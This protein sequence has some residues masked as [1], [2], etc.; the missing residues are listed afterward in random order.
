MLGR[1]KGIEKLK[2]I[3]DYHNQVKELYRPVP[4]EVK[5]FELIILKKQRETVAREKQPYPDYL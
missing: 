5:K 4:S 1:K 3:N 2:K